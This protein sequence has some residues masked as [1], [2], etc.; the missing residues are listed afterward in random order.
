MKSSDL[1]L[2]LSFE[3]IV[4]VMNVQKNNVPLPLEVPLGKNVD[5]SGISLAVFH[6]T[7]PGTTSIGRRGEGPAAGRGGRYMG[8]SINVNIGKPFAEP[9]NLSR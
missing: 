2:D 3:Q 8:P 5:K 9:P 6:S 1:G 7:S 4:R